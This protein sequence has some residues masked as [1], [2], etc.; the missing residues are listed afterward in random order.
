[1]AIEGLQS[2]MRQREM[3]YG[4]LETKEKTDTDEALK[5]FFDYIK[6]SNEQMMGICVTILDNQKILASKIDDI[7][8]TLQGMIT[9]KEE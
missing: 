5:L 6:S 3:Q 9:A 4:R 1:M 2:I 7:E 8:K